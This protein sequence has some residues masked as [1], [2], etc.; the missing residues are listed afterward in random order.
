MSARAYVT[1]LRSPGVPRLAA[2]FVAL[3]VSFTMTPVAFVLFARAATKSLPTAS[4]VLAGSTAGSLVVG[5]LRGRLVDRVGPRRAVLWLAA[6]GLATDV[7]FIAAGRA[8]VGGSGLVAL[9][10]VSGAVAAPAVSAL[11]TV[12]SRTL[13]EGEVRQA[14]YAVMSMLVETTYIVG[15]LVAGAVI[16]LGSPTSAVA[17]SAALQFT[18][19][20]GFA[21]SPQAAGPPRRQRRTPSGR[22]PALASRGTR[23]LALTAAAFGITF[24]ILDVAFPVFAHTH[25]SA[26]AA[27]VLLS[28]FAVGSWVGGFL[29][30]L[31]R[32]QT[33]AGRRYPVVCCFAAAGLAP[34]VLAPGLALM[35]ALAVLAGLCFAPTT[36]CQLA[37]IDDVAPAEHQGEALTWLGTLYGAGLALGAAVSGQ[38]IG[39]AG[40]RAA[41][42]GASGAAAL[43][44]IVAL[45]R[46][47]TLA[48]R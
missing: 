7:A 23:T 32:H 43:A 22:L 42:A 12:W 8:Q 30:G 10:F 16:A 41:L 2:A 40:I 39:I 9:A 15:P 46:A 20:V 14:G 27:G 5:P 17:L 33:P 29:Y 25:G 36:I 34:L 18:G 6:P 24:G 11:R 35:T 19:A 37:A 21:T 47:G 38:L 48:G 3:G 4:L 1:L 44:A 13:P 31:A 28:A 45:A 26:A